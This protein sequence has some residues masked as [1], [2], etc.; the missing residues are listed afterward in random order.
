MMAGEFFAGLESGVEGGRTADLCRELAGLYRECGA[1]LEIAKEKNA[2]AE[3]QKAALAA[4]RD[5]D[6]RCTGL[7]KELLA[8][9][10][11]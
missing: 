9:I 10:P 6:R 2:P 1:K 11:A 8:A 5:L 4:G 3:V 7:M